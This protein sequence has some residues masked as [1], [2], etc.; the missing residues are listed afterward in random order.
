[1]QALLDL[2]KQGRL[3]PVL[4]PRRYPIAEGREAMRL[5]DDRQVYG[6]VIVEPGA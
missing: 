4:H 5:L 6:K 2:V 3:N 1:V